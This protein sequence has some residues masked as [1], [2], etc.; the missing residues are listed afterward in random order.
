[1]TVLPSTGGLSLPQKGW[2]G[3]GILGWGLSWLLIAAHYWVANAPAG[4][5]RSVMAGPISL[6]IP[7]FITIGVSV[8]ILTLITFGSFYVTTGR[9]GD[10]AM[11]SAIA[12]A[13]VVFY[14]VLVTSWSV[15]PVTVAAACSA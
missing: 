14:A 5:V 10:E 11:R 8:G 2:W 1:M 15:L 13:L 9:T 12:A 4:E 3:I 6:D 7:Y